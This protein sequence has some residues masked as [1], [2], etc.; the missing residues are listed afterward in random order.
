[1]PVAEG[2]VKVRLSLATYGRRAFIRLMSGSETLLS[3]G[4]P[5]PEL[6]ANVRVTYTNHWEILCARD[7]RRGA[8]HIT[9]SPL[10]ASRHKHLGHDYLREGEKSDRHSCMVV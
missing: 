1:M 5:N 7:R 6:W 9:L 2:L 8:P 3:L 10:P 4:N